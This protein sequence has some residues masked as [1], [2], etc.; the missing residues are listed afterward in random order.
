MKGVEVKLWWKEEK[1]FL[2]RTEC[3]SVA[4]LQKMLI[5]HRCGRREQAEQTE[6][7][8]PIHRMKLEL[9]S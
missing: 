3:L 4:I 8:L 5:N 7:F 1:S 6:Q 2:G 9:K